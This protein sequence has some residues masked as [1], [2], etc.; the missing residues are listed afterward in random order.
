LNKELEKKVENKHQSEWVVNKGTN[1]TKIANKIKLLLGVI[2]HPIGRFLLKASSNEKG[3]R[4]PFPLHP[5][6]KKSQNRHAKG[7]FYFHRFLK[8]LFRSCLARRHIS[9]RIPPGR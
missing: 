6:Q 4:S 1:T 3:S 2:T 7:E 9:T 5:H 8:L